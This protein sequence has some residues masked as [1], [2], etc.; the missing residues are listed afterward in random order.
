MRTPTDPGAGP[1]ASQKH[2]IW[3]LGGTR[4]EAVKLAPL[5]PA[6]RERLL[7]PI[8]VATGQHPAMFRQ[9]LAAF[10][11]QPD[12]ELHPR[13]DTGSQAEL[14]AALSPQLELELQRAA[15]AAVVVQGDTTSALIGA[16]TAFWQQIPVVHLEA[17][18]RS[19]DLAAPFPEEANRRIIGQ[20]ATRHLAPTPRAAANLKTEGVATTSIDIVGNT[21]VDAVLR[22]AGAPRPFAESALCAVERTLAEGRRL[23]LV[24]VHRRESW[25]EPMRCVLRAVRDVL[26]TH[27][28][29]IAVVPAHPNP[30]VRADV[31]SVLGAVPR[32]V[33]TGP[34]DYPDL[35]RLLARAAIVMSDS[36]GIQEEAPTFGVPV[37]V[38][39]E[40]TERLEAVEA[41]CAYLVGTDRDRITKAARRLLTDTSAQ[42]SPGPCRNPFGD[43]RAADRAAAVIARLVGASS[44]RAAPFVPP[45]AS[46][47]SVRRPHEGLEV[48]MAF[49]GGGMQY[50]GMGSE[51][52]Q[53][54][55]RF[56]TFFDVLS[57]AT[58]E[59][60]RLGGPDL[61][62]LL[63]A[64]GLDE[65]RVATLQQPRAALPALLAVEVALARQL[66]AWGIRPRALIGHSIGEFTAAHLAGVFTLP[67]MLELAVRGGELIQRASGSGAMATVGLAEAEVLRRLEDGLSL[68]VVAADDECVVAGPA[69]AID[70]FIAS[71]AHEGIATHRV[72]L[73][74]AVHC[75]L[76]DPVLAEYTD[77]VRSLSLS[78]PTVPFVCNVTGTWI[79]E[80][81][82][83]D[84]DTWPRVLRNPA[85]FNDALAAVLA[86]GPTALIEV[87]PGFTLARYAQRQH[88]PPVATIPTL[89]HKNDIGVADVPLVTAL[90]RLQ[91]LGVQAEAAPGLTTDGARR[92][93]A[94]PTAAATDTDTVQVVIGQWRELL[95]VDQIRADDDY[96]SLGGDSVI[97]VRVIDVVARHFGVR[98]PL[99][100]LVESPTPAQ[101][102]AAIDAATSARI[103]VHGAGPLVPLR[104]TGTKR[105]F[106][107]VHGA[108]G[109]VLNLVEFARCIPS[110]RP[111]WG[112]AAHG[113]D[114]I[115]RPDGTIEQMAERYLEA[116]RAE[117]GAGPYLLGGYSGGGVVAL[118]MSRQAAHAD[119]PVDLVVMFDTHRPHISSP[120]TKQKLHNLLRYARHYG[121]AGIN[122]WITD[123]VGHRLTRPRRHDRPALPQTP[124]RYEDFLDALLRYELTSYPTDVV[125]LRAAPERPTLAFDYVWPEVTGAFAEYEVAGDHLTMFAAA[126]APALAKL[127]ASALDS[128][129]RATTDRSHAADGRLPAPG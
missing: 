17:G 122:A 21:V 4:P 56:G 57:E 5:V 73:S 51:I 25:G 128:A 69:A 68:A 80:Q 87:G 15:P 127:V 88:R 72:P 27:P 63:A 2:A 11:L 41:G 48:V 16:M 30:S 111:I 28:D 42:R 90:A 23:L 105:P 104:P 53:G 35:V 22:I 13:R 114:G 116:I 107:V 119:D 37:L 86:A 91:S 9:G 7:R 106:F 115:G 50:P 113:S 103:T 12:L 43:G 54:D 118:E 59:V 18:L 32:A 10:G 46:C 74:A 121:T 34:L 64:D 112:I 81:Q 20:L 31:E 99:A 123:V 108:G 84:P 36:G 60:R 39:R 95:R 44:R 58:E 75:E 94:L 14:V 85:R 117:Y 33:I 79:T 126:H 26:A 1:T 96:F 125:L 78:A 65:A 40:K 110:D 8:V 83:V 129:D 52:P 49:P 97:G 67:D 66:F 19:Q 100:T 124:G 109:N 101:L 76:L 29:T 71:L 38:L 92:I 62:P 82:A 70:R 120:T 3:L 102:A 6:L 61:R 89:R 93:A 77:L 47:A 45:R 24:T 98:L 55:S